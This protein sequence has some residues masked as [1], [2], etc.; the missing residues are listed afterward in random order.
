MSNYIDGF[1]IPL[2]KDKLES[3]RKVATRACAL[4]MEHGALEYVE[5][6]GD[7]LESSDQVPF[8]QIAGASDEETV[9][10]SYIVYRSREH[11]DKVNA[12]VISDPRL[13][14]ICADEGEPFD[15]RRMAYGGFRVI[16]S[17]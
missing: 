16:V 17:G 3:Y 1:V 11:R 5:A 6:V 14:E 4:W 2:S 13:H 7:D 9:V 10:F 12:R 15:C 8:P